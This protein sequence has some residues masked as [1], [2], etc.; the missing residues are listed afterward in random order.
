VLWTDKAGKNI[1][2]GLFRALQTEMG[3]FN[4]LKENVDLQGNIIE[5][6]RK[7]LYSQFH[8]IIKKEIEQEKPELDVRIE[9]ALIQELEKEIER[10]NEYKFSSEDKLYE[11]SLDQI[12]DIFSSLRDNNIKFYR[13]ILEDFK[14]NKRYYIDQL[15]SLGYS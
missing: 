12:K 6:T 4:Y 9:I 2:Y 3:Y 15:K 5:P 8:S 14:K 13:S 10:L 1:I 7:L 11:I